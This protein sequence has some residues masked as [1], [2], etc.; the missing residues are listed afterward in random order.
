[1]V[2]F[3]PDTN[4]V[5]FLNARR[6]RRRVEYLC[7]NTGRVIERSELANDQRELLRRVLDIPIDETA[8]EA[9]AARSQAEDSDAGLSD[10]GAELVRQLGDYELVSKL[11]Q[12]G[13][14][15]VYRASQPSLGRQVALKVLL[16]S[17][18]PKAEARFRREIQA[19]GQVEHP[20]LV[21]IFTSG[22]AGEQWFY[23]MELVEGTTLAD[24]CTHL[25]TPSSRPET[26][27]DAAWRVAV[28]T[29]TEQTRQAEQTLS[30]EPAAL[31]P[32][33]PTRQLT[34]PI[35]QR[36][37]LA[38]AS[39]VRQVVDLVRQVAEAA[40]ALHERGVI[41]RDIKPGNIMVGPAGDSAV[42]MD[43]GLAQVSDEI[44][45]KLT[46]T[47]QFVGT[48][49]YASPE[50]VMAV[51]RLDRR[52]DVYSLG[53]TLWEL[54]A[55]RP[56]F[57]AD[58]ATPTPQLMMQIQQ[59]DPGRVRRHQPAVPHDLDAI[60]GKC[61]EKKPD[62]RYATAEELAS[63]LAH[64][65]AGKPVLAR[66]VGSL[67]RTWRWI[68]RRPG[69]AA[70]LASVVLALLGGTIISMLFAVQSRNR[71]NE[72]EREQKRRAL[73]QVDRLC[74]AAPAAVPA[75]LAD[76][77]ENRAE[78]LPRLRELY[79]QESN[80]AK[81][82]RLAL[83]LLPV[84]PD[85]LQPALTEAML[86]TSEPS[87]MLLI[88]EALR[89]YRADL[90]E[91]L[92][93][94][95]DTAT[96][97]D[98]RFRALVALA[99]F[100]RDSAQWDEAHANRAVEHLLSVNSLHLGTWMEALR[101]VAPALRGRLVRAFHDEK[102][103]E[104]RLP[105]ATVLAGYAA[106]DPELLTDLVLDAEPK[107][108]ALLEPVL[109]KH[110]EKAADRLRQVLAQPVGPRWHDPPLEAAWGV[111]AA[112]W[113]REIERADGLVAERWALCH[114]LPLGRLLAVTEG[115]RSGGYRPLRVRP[116]LA[117]DEVR[118]AVVWTRDASD[119]RLV[120]DQTAVE[121]DRLNQLAGKK[122]EIPVDVAGYR[123]TTG[124]ERYTVVWSRS[125]KGEV[126]VLHVGLP[127]GKQFTLLEPMRKGGLVPLTLQA[128]HR[129]GKGPVYSSIWEK[130]AGRWWTGWQ[131]PE[132]ELFDP[133]Y[134]LADLSLL[135]R[136]DQVEQLGPELLS[137]L[138]GTSMTGIA[139]WPWV[140]M[141]QARHRPT[142]R[143]RDWWY[144]G[145]WYQGVDVA[146]QAVARLPL[147]AHLARCR[148]LAQ[149]GYRPAG[150]T[151][152]NGQSDAGADAASVWHRPL[153]LRLE[154]ERLGRQH[155]QAAATLLHLGETEQVWPL[156][157]R[158]L[159]PEVRSQLVWRA[160]LLKVEP[161]LLVKRLNEETDV[162]AKRALILALGEYPAEQLPADLREPLVKTLLHWYRTDPD[163]G[164]HGAI[165]WLLRHGKEGES[166]RPLD[167]GKAREL[168]LIEAQLRQRDP[169]PERR[170][171]VNQQG[172][173]MVLIPGPVEF[174]MGSPL[175]E[176]GHK[177]YEVPHRRRISRSFA[178]AA[179]PVTVEEFQRYRTD[180]G[181]GNN[182]HLK[183]YSP[184][185]GGP[186]INVSWYM[187][188]QYCNWLS[189]KEG[190][191]RD[192]WCYPENP[193][194]IKEGMKLKAGHLQRTGYRLP[195]EAEWEYACRAETESSRYYGSSLELLPRYAWYIKNS[196]DRTRTVGQKRP[197]DF[198]LF[199]MHGNVW[200]LCQDRYRDYPKAKDG[201]PVEDVEDD[202]SV[203]Y[204]D[205]RALRGGAYGYLP[206]LVRSPCRSS[207]RPGE[208]NPYTG[209]RIARTYR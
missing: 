157:R 191:P 122:G 138:A 77:A 124:E 163:A 110:R 75:I 22:S 39:Y 174:R 137:W 32:G 160:G 64:F 197:N 12:G 95:A 2:C 49:R 76:L 55:L 71:A 126:R 181:L 114:S 96:D 16:R 6:N 113:Q 62:Q 196:E 182:D 33:C 159:D 74:D 102:A 46:K 201:K 17:G 89:P 149:Q 161:G 144:A 148:E 132:S 176:V 59:D 88:R 85:Q 44:D 146:A 94:K 180:R 61:L 86:H 1:L 179:R 20:N 162:T 90:G 43:L 34:Q 53:A 209:F 123:L 156:F 155:A 10:P 125:R 80:T 54:L 154:E 104:L 117:G 29:V 66:P 173:T 142:Q 172:Q 188:A 164:V 168:Q 145:V 83:A 143:V 128:F 84:E 87:E 134:F 107:Q 111:P 19:L 127:D 38:T 190:I 115:M 199:D 97:A 151:V 187:A 184:E 52:S 166:P 48:L 133:N 105:A 131:Q 175:L 98:V 63:D 100:D 4:E 141:Y 27:D 18:D 51:A 24:V 50:Q 8:T 56:L 171:Y 185:P 28:H 208:D 91:P 58:D 136:T 139:G 23:A 194:E 203:K 118:V 202:E 99:A 158:S 178:I 200:N 72:L 165:D 41:H 147:A 65:L 11:G 13:M 119:W 205:G 79:D 106:N 177:S 153:P 9:W 73:A 67:A 108:Y 195:T 170:W 25:T 192:H 47:R 152:T 36:A 7:Y 31:A 206:G 112:E 189:E 167:W 70:L 204:D 3:E 120:L 207:F 60:V 130:Q 40:H 37:L 82:M 81:R 198:G 14:G 183:E 57:G 15:A 186:M 135:G 21:K 5:L 35:C 129:P 68:K 150:L 121:V 78:V 69:T 30:G 103:P 92:W 109:A 116:Y 26:L 93:H 42:L 193:R 140:G 45:G 101:P 169:D